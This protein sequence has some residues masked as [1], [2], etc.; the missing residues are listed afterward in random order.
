MSDSA[1]DFF[2]DFEVVAN[3]GGSD[4]YV[5]I[6]RAAHFSLGIENAVPTI[7]GAFGDLDSLSVG[8]AI[9]VAGDSYQVAQPP[10]SD[11]EGFLTTVILKDA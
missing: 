5:V 1:R 9:T 10:M 11:G 8:D 2:S 3:T 6:D 7:M 4:F